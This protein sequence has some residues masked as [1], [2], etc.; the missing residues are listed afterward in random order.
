MRNRPAGRWPSYPF[1]VL[2][3]RGDTFEMPVEMLSSLRRAAKRRGRETG[4]KY[5]VETLGELA[6]VTRR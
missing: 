3:A 4:I 1:H 6:L 5:V 2:A